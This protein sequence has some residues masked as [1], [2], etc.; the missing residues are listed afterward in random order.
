MN[1]KVCPTPETLLTVKSQLKRCSVKQQQQQ[2]SV[3]SAQTPGDPR[4]DFLGKFS[5]KGVVC[6]CLLPNSLHICAFN[7]LSLFFHQR[8][9]FF[10]LACTA[11][12]RS[13]NRRPVASLMLSS[14]RVRGFPCLLFPA[15]C[16]SLMF[17]SSDLFVLMT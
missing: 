16:P 8:T 5:C 7:I 17:C 2:Q 4:E 14:H 15:T 6:L 10:F 3:E 12:F 11:S 13:S 1:V 9:P